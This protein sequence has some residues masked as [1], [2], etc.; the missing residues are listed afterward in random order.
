MLQTCF[1]VYLWPGVCLTA[2]GVSDARQYAVGYMD[3]IAM[4]LWG[5]EHKLI[6]SRWD[7]IERG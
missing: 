4:E 7:V 2:I 1:S 3:S 5:R 6:P